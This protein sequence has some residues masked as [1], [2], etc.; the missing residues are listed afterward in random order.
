M[1]TDVH[2]AWRLD[3]SGAVHSLPPGREA[4]GPT[5]YSAAARG[6]AHH[7]SPFRRSSLV[8]VICSLP[9]GTVAAGAAAS[10]CGGVCHVSPGAPA[11]TAEGVFFVNLSRRGSFLAILFGM[12]SFLTKIRFD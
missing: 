7:A 3:D 4:A 2:A 9:P 10:L 5:T 1:R 11:A 8:P 12:W 6:R